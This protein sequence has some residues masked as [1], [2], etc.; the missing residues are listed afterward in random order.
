MY[1]IS[2]EKLFIQEYFIDFKPPVIVTL[3][4]KEIHC[5]LLKVQYLILEGYV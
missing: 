2:W 5:F 4:R 3:D 1:R